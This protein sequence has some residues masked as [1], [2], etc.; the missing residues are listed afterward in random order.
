M[1]FHLSLFK[2]FGP[3]FKNIKLIKYLKNIILIIYYKNNLL[4]I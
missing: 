4:K 1:E 2:L 3:K